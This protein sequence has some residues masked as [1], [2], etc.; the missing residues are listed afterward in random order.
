MAT[1]ARDVDWWPTSP[2]PPRRWALP[3]VR[4]RQLVVGPGRASAYPLSGSTGARGPTL[5]ARSSSAPG[6]EMINAEQGA[7]AA[8]VVH[9]RRSRAH[10]CVSA[11]DVRGSGSNCSR[12]AGSSLFAKLHDLCAPQSGQRRGGGAIRA[13]QTPSTRPNA[14]GYLASAIADEIRAVLRSGEIPSI[15]DRWKP[16]GLSTL[17]DGPELRPEAVWA[18][19][20][21]SRL[22]AYPDGDLATAPSE[23]MDYATPAA[24]QGDLM[25]NPNCPDEEMIARRSALTPAKL[26]A[27]RV[28]A[29]FGRSARCNRRQ[30]A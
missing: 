5:D 16:W 23:R 15:T 14:Q 7:S 20:C 28:M 29:K 10:R 27:R 6:V 26:H 3:A 17:A 25:Q 22:V 2:R 8:M 18:S 19:R 12:Q 21:R 11:F 30:R 13:R 24:A 9:H 1:A 4:R